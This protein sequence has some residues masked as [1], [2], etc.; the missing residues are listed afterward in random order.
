[1]RP[2]NSFIWDPLLFD[3]N[4]QIILYQEC[5]WM[6]T[7]VKIIN[8][9]CFKE[10]ESKMRF[11]TI[12]PL[13][14]GVSQ[15]EV[16]Q[17]WASCWLHTVYRGNKFSIQ[18]ATDMQKILNSSIQA[19]CSCT[20]KYCMRPIWM[21]GAFSNL[22]SHVLNLRLNIWHK[23]WVNN[24]CHIITQAW[25]NEFIGSTRSKSVFWVFTEWNSL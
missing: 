18:S 20:S 15:N 5:F 19:N 21:E 11:Y 17:N 7:R 2:H 25:W 24:A 12:S 6:K 23:T 9:L 8:I 3:T 22:S 10:C 14:D 13:H 1:M 4:W 16:S